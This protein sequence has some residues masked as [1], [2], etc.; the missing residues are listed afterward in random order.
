M[1]D[2]RHIIDAI[3]TCTFSSLSIDRIDIISLAFNSFS[4]QASCSRVV[5]TVDLKSAGRVVLVV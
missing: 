5:M 2:N 3:Q 4:Y 1:K